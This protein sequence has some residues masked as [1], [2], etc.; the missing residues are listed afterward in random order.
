MKQ[1]VKKRGRPEKKD[2][3]IMLN[4]ITIRLPEPMMVE[5]ESMMSARLDAPDKSA[6]IR[7]LIAMGIQ[8]AKAKR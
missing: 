7:E 1:P 8:A 2:G 6:V 5:I 4:P 3:D